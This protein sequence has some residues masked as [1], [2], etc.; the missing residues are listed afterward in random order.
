VSSYDLLFLLLLL[1]LLM[2]LPTYHCHE[3]QSSLLA[4]FS[5]EFFGFLT[6]GEQLL[7]RLERKNV[8]AAVKVGDRSDDCI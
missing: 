5:F 4:T 1:I 7:C 3:W 8:L 6:V 2:L